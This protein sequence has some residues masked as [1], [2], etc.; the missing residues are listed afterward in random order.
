MGMSQS[1][2]QRQRLVLIGGDNAAFRQDRNVPLRVEVRIIAG[3][4]AG[5][6]EAIKMERYINHFFRITRRL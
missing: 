5:P 6:A 3:A 1:L 2:G 4:F